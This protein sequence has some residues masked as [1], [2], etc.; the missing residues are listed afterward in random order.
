MDLAVLLENGFPPVRVRGRGDFIFY[1]IVFALE[2]QGSKRKNIDW[3]IPAAGG[4]PA[5]FFFW[6]PPLTFPCTGTELGT[7]N[8]TVSSDGA[9]CVGRPF[10]G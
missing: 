9:G 3:R 1:F 10:V 4:V 5:P 7:E 6:R 2:V 8:R